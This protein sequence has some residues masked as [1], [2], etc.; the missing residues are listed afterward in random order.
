MVILSD[1]SAALEFAA[2]MKSDTVRDILLASGYLLP[3]GAP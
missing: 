2:F 3:D 1:S